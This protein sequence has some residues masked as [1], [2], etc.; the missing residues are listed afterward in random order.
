MPM[1]TNIFSMFCTDAHVTILLYVMLWI[2][3]ALG[4]VESGGTEGDGD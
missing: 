1:H 2:E 3:E 4:T